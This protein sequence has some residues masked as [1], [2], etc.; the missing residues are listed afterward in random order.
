[1]KTRTYGSYIKLSE[2]KNINLITHKHSR[3][4]NY[5]KHNQRT[6]NEIGIDPNKLIF[7]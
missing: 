7:I 6:N 5:K 2:P 1:M 3:F 4:E